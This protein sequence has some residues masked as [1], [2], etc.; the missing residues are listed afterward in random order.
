MPDAIVMRPG[1]PNEATPTAPADTPRSLAPLFPDDRLIAAADL[2]R[3]IGLAIQTLARLRH[4]G[5]GPPF[6]RVGRRIFYRSSD[7]R[8]WLNENSFSNTSSY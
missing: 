4:E 3:Y 5:K 8:V 6:V 1:A 2:P 7:V